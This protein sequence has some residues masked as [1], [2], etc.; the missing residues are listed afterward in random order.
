MLA[1]C[2][3]CSTRG[4]ISD[5]VFPPSPTNRDQQ[6]A[7]DIYISNIQKK[8]AP[9]M[10]NGTMH[11]QRGRSLLDEQNGNKTVPE[12]NCAITIYTFKEMAVDLHRLIVGMQQRG[13]RHTHDRH[14]GNSRIRCCSPT[15]NHV[16]G[17]PQGVRRDRV[18]KQRSAGW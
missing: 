15:R 11:Q 8:H 2:R 5:S 6:P 7:T 9:A 18:A 3:T 17:L 16:F 14:L 4:I 1:A 12:I 10:W 13:P